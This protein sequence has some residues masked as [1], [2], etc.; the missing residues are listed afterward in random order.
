MFTAGPVEVRREVLAKMTGPMITHRGREY[1]QLHASI[2]EKLRSLLR[3]DS[4]ILL[5]VSSATGAME[6]C[7]RSCVEKRILHLTSGAFSERWVEISRSNAKQAD[8]V[9][10]PWGQPVG[11]SS[12]EGS[13]MAEYD[14]VAVTHNETSTG[15]MNPIEE[16]AD[17]VHGESEALLFVDAVTSAFANVIDLARIKPDF[18]LFGTQK[19]LA[20]PPGLAFAVVSDRMFEKAKKTGNRGRYF[21]LLEIKEF[22]DRHLVPSTPPISLMY[23]LDYQ[24]DR[25]SREGMERRAER[26]RRMAEMAR[27][28]ASEHLGLFPSGSYSNTVTCV[29]NTAGKAFEEIDGKLAASGYQISE[30]YGKLKQ[31]TFRIGHMGDLTTA[32]LSGLLSVMTEIFV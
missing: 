25:I 6:S 3:T 4:S 17:R 12:V 22:A 19:A 5:F 14:A 23:A 11:A 16:V 20:L 30:G 13:P 21:D 32:E 10:V 31:A 28:W 2:V 15:V 26:H 9:S 8:V 27:R 7:I 18:L 1:K 29:N 24:L